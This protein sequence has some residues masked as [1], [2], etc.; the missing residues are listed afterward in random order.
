MPT[1]DTS[2]DYLAFDNT[3]TVMLTN[4]DD[5]IHLTTYALQEGIDTI[6]ADM[7]DG[8][9]GFRTFCIWHVWKKNLNNFTPKIN[10]KIVDKEGYVW[11]VANIRVDVWGEKYQ[12]DCEAEAG[13]GVVSVELP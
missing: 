9:L 4:P 13:Q 12:L 5:S 1:I 6:M 8:N 11:Y 3:Q 7:G 2:N 10:C